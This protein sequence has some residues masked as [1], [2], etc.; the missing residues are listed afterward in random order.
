M[1][2]VGDGSLQAR[3]PTYEYEPLISQDAIRILVLHPAE[4]ESDPLKGSIIQI[5]RYSEL[6]KPGD[7]QGYCA[8]SYAWGKSKFSRVLILE[9]SDSNVRSYLPISRIVEAMLRYFREPKKPRYLWIDAICLNQQDEDEKGKQIPEM[10]EIFTSADKVHIWLGTSNRIDYAK[11]FTYLRLLALCPGQTDTTQIFG[12][13]YTAT[14]QVRSFFR[15]PWFHRRWI[16]QEASLAQYGI[17]HLGSYSI[18]YSLLVLACKRLCNLGISRNMYGVKMLVALSEG[19][20]DI[21]HLLWKLHGSACSDKRDRVAA[22]QGFIPRGLQQPLEYDSDYKEIYK[23]QAIRLIDSPRQHEL[24]L[25]LFQFGALQGT[26]GSSYPSWIPDWSRKRHSSLECI[27]P[28]PDKSK[29]SQSQAPVILGS[30][31]TWRPREHLPADADPWRQWLIYGSNSKKLGAILSHRRDDDGKDFLNVR[32]SNPEAGIYGRTV[33]KVI[34]IT[35]R[36]TMWEEWQ[37]VS[38]SLKPLAQRA[39]R[40][41]LRVLSLLI[42]SVMLRHGCVSISRYGTWDRIGMVADALEL[43]VTGKVP[44]STPIT[45]AH[46][47]NN[48]PILKTLATI[49]CEL[50]TLLHNSKL[51]IVELKDPDL[52]NPLR[53][54]CRKDFSKCNYAVGPSI[55]KKGMLLIPLASSLPDSNSG[56]ESYAWCID[57]P[58]ESYYSMALTNMLA[59]NPCQPP[60]EVIAGPRITEFGSQS[61]AEDEP[62]ALKVTY[63]GLCLGMLYWNSID[64]DLLTQLLAEKATTRDEDRVRRNWIKTIKKANPPPFMVDII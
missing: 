23:Q 21:Y 12:N 43:I 28:L 61:E 47:E 48:T 30:Y 64:V 55:L 11:M 60:K 17:V 26:D 56:K 9:G 38:D 58:K 62:P 41:G 14:S 36:I 22:L 13:D 39:K 18:S 37:V 25:H 49:I 1:A 15:R 53:C 29:H 10:G 51:A 24:L 32:W 40:R 45:E 4:I 20:Q 6:V 57:Y 2:D 7:R 16:L 33:S 50:G 3:T 63:V 5:K 54:T 59:V 31:R 35:Q 42:E 8:L 52:E 46:I 19:D 44:T 34:T 27:F